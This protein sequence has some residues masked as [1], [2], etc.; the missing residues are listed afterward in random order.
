[1]LPA[2]EYTR[3]TGIQI[4]DF[5]SILVKTIPGRPIPLK[6]KNDDTI[7][8]VKQKMMDEEVPI[9]AQRLILTA[10]ELQDCA[11][12]YEY[13]IQTGNSLH[14]AVRLCSL[15]MIVPAKKRVLA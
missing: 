8:Q 10:M 12:L 4:G 3:N 13:E 15:G 7:L 1:M 14:I 6:V 11:Y 5:I 9:D 2:S